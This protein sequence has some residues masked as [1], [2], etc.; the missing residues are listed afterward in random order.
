MTN[1]CYSYGIIINGYITDSKDSAC[2]GS[3][4][5]CKHDPIERHLF[6]KLDKI[7]MDKRKVV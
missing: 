3:E 4:A 5:K 2:I 1:I 7:T 6:E